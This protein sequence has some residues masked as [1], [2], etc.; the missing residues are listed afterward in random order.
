ML[1]VARL[2][3]QG[4]NMALTKEALER[5]E[6]KA[7]AAAEKQVVEALQKLVNSLEV[8]CYAVRP[9]EKPVWVIELNPPDPGTART[10]M[11]RTAQKRREK[12]GS[13]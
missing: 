5:A 13:K 2:A 9:T 11:Y 7:T 4:E 1:V 6:R 10:L 8:E 3:V 12:H